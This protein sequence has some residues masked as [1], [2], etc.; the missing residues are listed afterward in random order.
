MTQSRTH[1]IP[2][3]GITIDTIA[4]AIADALPSVID[5][6]ILCPAAGYDTTPPNPAIYCPANGY[7]PDDSW[8]PPVETVNPDGSG[9]DQI[10]L[11]CD[12]LGGGAISVSFTV[13]SGN[14]RFECLT[15][16]MTVIY[17]QEQAAN[18]FN[19]IF[20]TQG[21]GTNY[22]IRLSCV[23]PASNITV[24]ARSFYT[25]YSTN[26][27]ILQAK[28]YTPNIISISGAFQSFTD[29]KE[30]IF[31]TNVNSLTNISNAF[32]GSGIEKATWPAQMNG[33]TTMQSAFQSTFN[34]KSLNLS[35]T[36][37]NLLSNLSSAFRYSSV[38]EI[39]LPA[40]LPEATSF[41]NFAASTSFLK[42]FILP[43]SMPKVTRIDYMFYDS[44]ILEGDYTY[45]EMPLCTT[46]SGAFYNTRVRK[47]AFTG[48][49][50]LCASSGGGTLASGCSLL[51]EL[52]L[53]TELAATYSD[54]NFLLNA[55]RLK[56]FTPPTNITF[57]AGWWGVF[58]GGLVEQFNTATSWGTAQHQVS[59]QSHKLSAF[60]QPTLR[61]TQL[62]V[63]YN[64]SPVINAPLTSVD[65]DFANSSFSATGGLVIRAELPTAEIN[66]IYTALPT[67]VGKTIAVNTCPGFAAANH[68]IAQAKGWTVTGA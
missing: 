66:R 9:G 18:I 34:L 52:I 67:V 4:D 68:A 49:M 35:G 53:P 2:V 38:S 60:N 21:T 44:K 58:S 37:F 10:L 5:L 40:S 48:A 62:V 65:I 31:L 16:D 42:S 1:Y 32:N 39:R 27:R 61:V 57:T 14:R 7:F 54:S 11:L 47:I 26:H 59:L 63:G 6:D 50:P 15:T 43:T 22:I 30:I 64:G 41:Q 25:G 51:E 23:N 13:S 56:K 36:S 45:P 20:P 33:V 3:S 46:Y 12:D 17:T 55:V 8:V 24:F 28:F 29:F 19:Y